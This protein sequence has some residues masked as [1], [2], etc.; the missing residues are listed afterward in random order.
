MPYNSGGKSTRNSSARN[1]STRSNPSRRNGV[2][3]AAVIAVLAVLLGVGY[4]VQSGRDTTGDEAKTPGGSSVDVGDLEVTA[5]VDK[6]GLGVGDPDAP[7]KVEIFEDFL[8]PY[9]KQFEDA[10]NDYL[11]Q[12]A[13]D[14]KVYVVYRPIAFLNEYS[15]RA[16]NTFAVVQDTAGP[17]EALA[18][19][20]ALFADQP[21]EAGAMPDDAWLVERAVDAG[22]TE[23]KVEAGIKTDDF[24]QWILNGAD[25]A[26]KR[27]VSGTPSVFVDGEPV[28][29]NSIDEMASNV[30]DLVES[31]QK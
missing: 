12:A 14:G 26:S 5:N 15:A 23:T 3:A 31:G 21:S 20:D 27:G 2:I 10:S 9:C 16:L 8:C 18:F 1:N 29:G 11:R 4:L 13:A 22:A 28:S 7:V 30:E 25:D 19:H 24:R 6:Y 17:Q